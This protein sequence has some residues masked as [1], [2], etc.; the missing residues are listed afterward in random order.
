MQVLS[1]FPKLD[2]LKTG[3]LNN[4]CHKVLTYMLI[5]WMFWH[6]FGLA[7]WVLCH[8]TYFTGKG[9][10]ECWSKRKGA[11]FLLKWFGIFVFV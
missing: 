10:A 9:T 3:I 4:F 5:S 1:Y 11:V 7:F 8:T 2:F 6:S